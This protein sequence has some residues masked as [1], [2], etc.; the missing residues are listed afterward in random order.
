MLD[1]ITYETLATIPLKGDLQRPMGGAMSPDGKFLYMT[2]GRGK[3]VAVIDAAAR[4][5]TAKVQVG[6]RPWGIV[7][8][9]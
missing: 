6:D 5:V 7:Y 8:L 9:P 1:T 2:T 3:T 4:R